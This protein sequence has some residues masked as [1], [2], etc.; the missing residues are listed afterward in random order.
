MFNGKYH[1]KKHHHNRIV[2]EVLNEVNYLLEQDIRLKGLAIKVSKV[3]ET[4]I[5]ITEKHWELDPDRIVSWSWRQI[6]IK[7]K[8]K[9]RRLCLSF[10]CNGVLC[11]MLFC[12]ASRHGLNVNVRYLEG[13]PDS[14]HP[15]KKYIMDIALLSVYT[16]AEKINAKTVMIQGPLPGV[17]EKYLQRGFHPNQSDTRRL[18]KGEAPLYKTLEK[19]V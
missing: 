12:S 14:L 4:D 11:G 3:S 10:N 8:K 6:S 19:K 7:K 18:K 1:D 2:N 15:L 16:Y 13:N 9:I 5:L 17:V